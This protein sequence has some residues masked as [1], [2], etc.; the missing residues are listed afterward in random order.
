LTPAQQTALDAIA[1]EAQGIA[2]AANPA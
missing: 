2:T 1:A